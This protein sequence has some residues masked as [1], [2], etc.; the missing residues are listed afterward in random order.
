MN[1]TN[2]RSNYI[3]SATAILRTAIN[4]IDRLGT[5]S[6]TSTDI[7]P[8]SSQAQPSTSGMNTTN[9]VSLNQLN[10]SIQSRA[11]DNFR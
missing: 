5:E 2:E 1:K 3:S 9:N 8:C 11:Q 7:G 6:A 10:E 4:E